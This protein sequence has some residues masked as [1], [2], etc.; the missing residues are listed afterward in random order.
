MLIVKVSAAYTKWN[1]IDNIKDII[2]LNKDELK[3]LNEQEKYNKVCELNVL[4]QV[5]NASSTT[6]VQNAWKN[7]ANLTIHG[8]IYCISDGILHDLKLDKNTL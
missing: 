1:V 6:I 3:D 5:K 7:N 8:W 4:E 2:K